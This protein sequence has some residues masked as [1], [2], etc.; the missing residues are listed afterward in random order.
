MINRKP[1]KCYLCRETIQPG[2]IKKKMRRN[3][4]AHGKCYEKREEKEW[5]NKLMQDKE[6]G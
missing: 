5:L 1:C 4:W 3:N 2:Q 6:S